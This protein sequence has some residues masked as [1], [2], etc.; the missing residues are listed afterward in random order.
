MSTVVQDEVKSL[1]ASLPLDGTREP[2][3]F[4]LGELAM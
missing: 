2:N 4:H 3:Q 1:D